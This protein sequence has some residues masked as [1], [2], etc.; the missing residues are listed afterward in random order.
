MHKRRAVT[1]LLFPVFAAIF[2]AGWVLYSLSEP[3][4]AK[5][6]A[7]AKRE[8]ATEKAAEQNCLKMG[9]TAELT[10]DEITAK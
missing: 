1:I 10:Q 5:N 3:K 8:F 9:L 2:L 6:I 7:S 4:A